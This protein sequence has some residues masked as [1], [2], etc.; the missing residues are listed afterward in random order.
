[1]PY[2]KNLTPYVNTNNNKS[3]HADGKLLNV[4]WLSFNQAFN[5]G[6]V[7]LVLLL[8]ILGILMPVVNSYTN[9]ELKNQN[10]EFKKRNR[11]TKS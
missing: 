8:I 5:K 4:G 6:S 9:K 1:M 11:E 7:H 3:N 10:V 2:Y